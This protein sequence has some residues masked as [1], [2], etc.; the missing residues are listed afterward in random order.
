[1]YCNTLAKD[2]IMGIVRANRLSQATMRK[3]NQNFF[4]AFIYN[5]IGIPLAVGILYLSFGLLLSPV[6]ASLAKSLSSVSVIVNSLRLNKS[7]I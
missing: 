4:F 5:I 1:M 3:I 6:F 2:D 7:K